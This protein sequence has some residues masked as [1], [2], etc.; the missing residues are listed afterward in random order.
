MAKLYSIY[1]QKGKTESPTLDTKAQW[2]IV[3]KGFP[4]M[5]YGENKDLP[6]RDWADQ[7]GEDTFFPEEIKL[8]AYDIEVEFAYKGA[9]GTANSK[10]ESFLDYLTGKGDTGT[11]LKVYD[12][13]TKIGRQ[14]VY[15]KSI[16]QDL[17]VR[18]SDEGDVVTFKI[19]FRVTDPR[20]PITLSV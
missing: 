16:D 5:P 13:Y 10:I 6:T 1:Y 9:I 2:S 8:K 7:D 4:F 3:C 18:K 14:G 15:Y 19:T 17:F 12:T 11:N 20:T